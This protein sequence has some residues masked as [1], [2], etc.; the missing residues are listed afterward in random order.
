MTSTASSSL[1]K[2][3]AEFPH[4]RLLAA[5][6]KVFARDGLTGATTREIA[7]EAGVNEVTLFRLFHTK[8]NLLA[9]VLARVFASPE[10]PQSSGLEAPSLEMRLTEEM[11]L[12][13][14]I[15]EYAEN[16]SAHLGKN[17]AL[18]R[19]LIGEIQHFQEHQQ[20]VMRCIILPDRQSL[21]D[22]LRAA[23]EAR[24]VRRELDP[25]IIADQVGALVFMGALRSSLPSP[26]E[27]SASSYLRACVET[28]VRAIEA[29]PRAQPPASASQFTPPGL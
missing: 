4:E 19:V 6:A 20:M 10:P 17:F 27:Y 8:L 25:V 26:P 13:E 15:Q 18:V 29:P 14:I 7:R 5:G 23:R 21:I 22:R 1:T 9:K 24:M 2:A 3:V 28:I 16:Y 12:T 11:C